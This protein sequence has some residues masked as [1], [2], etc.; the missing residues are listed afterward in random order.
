MNVVEKQLRKLD[1]YQQRRPRLGYIFGVI[2]KYG[3]DKGST[4]TNLLTYSMFTT[5]FP[6]LLLLVTIITLLLAGYPTIR[7]DILNSTFNEFP[8]VGSQ[9]SSN[10]HVLRKDS[11]IALI[12]GLLVLA[13]GSTNLA[14]NGIYVME[15]VWNIQVALRP[16]FFNRLLRS[17]AFLVVLAVGLVVTTFLSTFGTYSRHSLLLVIL[18]EIL[19]IAVNIVIV[20]AAFRT[21]TPKPISTRTLLPG[22]IFAGIVWTILQALGG[23]IV[24]HYL[25]NDN[26][27]YGVFGAVLGLIAWLYF[28][29]LVT[30]YAAE[31]NVVIKR[32]LWPRTLI[33]PPLTSA[34]QE[35]LALQVI[36]RRQR[37][38]QSVATEVRGQPLSEDQFLS[39]E[40][41]NLKRVGLKQSAP[42]SN[43][44]SKD[45]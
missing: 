5:V 11:V 43:D 22:S 7:H 32:H 41:V 29:A 21:L 19:A 12:V 10:F 20:F 2:K 37:L 18:F 40:K 35:A 27:T 33:Q 36:Q 3:D 31:I 24:G 9:L 26:V 44:K 23:F 6:L 4:L 8:L 30:V 1:A 34:D 38:E 25:R 15:Q 42:N 39:G 13:Y 17:L 28:A 14:S 45:I 16:S